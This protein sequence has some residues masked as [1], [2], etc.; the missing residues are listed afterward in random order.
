MEAA[1]AILTH[2]RQRAAQGKANTP[3]DDKEIEMSLGILLQH[4]SGPENLHKA[5]AIL[6][7]LHSREAGKSGPCDDKEIELAL[8]SCL[9]LSLIHI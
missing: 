9:M 6:T 8:A 1:L 3:C 5:L 7:R 2:Q 4:M